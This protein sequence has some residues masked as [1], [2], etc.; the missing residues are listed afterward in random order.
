MSDDIEG[1]DIKKIFDMFTIEDCFIIF[2]IMLLFAMYIADKNNIAAC[3]AYY[4]AK[5]QSKS[6]IYNI[7][8]LAP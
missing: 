4:I 1:G 6:F 7:S 2:L 5:E 3:N 8:F